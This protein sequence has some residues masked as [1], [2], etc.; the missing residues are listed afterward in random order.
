MRYIKKNAEPPFDFEQWK[1]GKKAEI[2]GKCV[3]YEISKTKENKKE[4]LSADIVWNLLPSSPAKDDNDFSKAQLRTLLL[5]EQGYLCAYCGS[6]I[7]NNNHVRGDHVTPKSLAIRRTFD[8]YNLVAACSGGDYIWHTIN[9]SETLNNIAEKYATTVQFIKNL[10]PNLN[11]EEN[12]IIEVHIGTN[13][14]IAI[15]TVFPHCDVK[16]ADKEHSIKPTDSDC[17]AKFSYS[18]D[19]KILGVDAAAKMTIGVLGLNDN[20][21]LIEKRRNIYIRFNTI[22]KIISAP[23]IPKE[24]KKN[25]LIKETNKTTGNKLEEMVFVKD[26][27]WKTLSLNP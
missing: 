13:R 21:F 22:L 16:K 8:Y 10:N 1:E 4:H 14:E 26:Y 12:E 18:A 15:D 7:E 11:F 17:Q 6:L 25:I 23:N 24:Q 27:F 19:G 3:A 20:P 5:E 9:K 2:E